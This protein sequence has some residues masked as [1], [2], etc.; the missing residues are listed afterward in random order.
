M[1]QKKQNAATKPRGEEA[2]RTALDDANATDYA[3]NM[4]RDG[5][6]RVAHIHGGRAYDEAAHTT[7]A[8]DDGPYDATDA[9]QL[10]DS[11]LDVDD[12]EATAAPVDKIPHMND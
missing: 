1:V 7:Q 10:L 4:F 12:L 9:E 2:Q 3:D 8:K 6:N 5:H 11:T